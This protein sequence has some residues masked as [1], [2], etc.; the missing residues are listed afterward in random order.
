MNAP[1][2]EIT[3][4]CWPGNPAWPLPAEKMTV[5]PLATAT[6]IEAASTTSAA[7]SA[8]GEFDPQLHVMMSGRRATAAS[9]APIVLTKFILTGSNWQPGAMARMFAD[10]PV[11]CPDSSDSASDA[12]GPSSTGATLYHWDW[13]YAWR[14]HPESTIATRTPA[15]VSP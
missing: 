12:P 6:A 8:N 15:P 3:S 5:I 7:L 11:P 13:K 1:P 9:K 2:A 14:Y 10:S 4:G